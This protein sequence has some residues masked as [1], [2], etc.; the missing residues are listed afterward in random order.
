MARRARALPAEYAA[1]ARRI[2]QGLCST[3]RGSVGP[4]EA[5]LRTYDPVPGLVFGAWGEASPDVDR[6]IARFAARGAETH[7]RDMRAETSSK[8]SGA[9]R[10]G[11]SADD[12]R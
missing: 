6:L 9:S 5:H 12:G 11:C 8:S 10:L 2:A 7:W 3:G 1:K 4:V